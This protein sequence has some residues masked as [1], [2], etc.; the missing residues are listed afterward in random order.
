MAL[1]AYLLCTLTS[2][3]CV[4]L[5]LRSYRRSKI[6][7]LL[8][9]GLCFVGL[10]L[11]NIL[12]IVDLLILPEIDLAIVRTI[13]TLVGLLVLIVGLVWEYGKEA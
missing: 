11:N 9:V 3:L 2:L 10:S 12:L 1:A 13:P 6:R 4:V 5:L 8:W 7:L